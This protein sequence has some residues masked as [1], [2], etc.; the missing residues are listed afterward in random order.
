MTRTVVSA[1]GIVCVIAVGCADGDGRAESSGS[2]AVA[3]AHSGG[4]D[5]TGGS[6]SDAG[7]AGRDDGSGGGAGTG[8][9][10]AGS[11]GLGDG[12]G[13]DGAGERPYAHVTA[14]FASGNP[15]AYTFAVSVESADVDCSQYADFWE[16]LGEDGSLVYRRVLEHSHT[17]ENGTSDP[18][19][20]GNTFTRSGGPIEI[21]A[22]EVVI[23]RAH[24]SNAG[25]NGMA[26]RGSV[27]GGFSAA[28][29]IEADFAADVEDDEPQ[30]QACLF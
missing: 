11:G 8:G 1:L 26:M 10:D 6:G 24:M 30:P 20:P 21:A 22:D 13:G 16:V 7:T 12:G 27:S 9:L 15:L 23:V 18:D 17:D 4:R 19:A 5:G 25:Y 3:G 29:E 2:G 14:V 28:P